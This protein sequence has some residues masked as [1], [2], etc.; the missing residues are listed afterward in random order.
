[1][2]QHDYDVENAAGVA[3]RQ[4]LNAVLAAIASL[5]SG[6]TEP[7][8]TFAYMLWA[9]TAS[10]YLKL[11]NA[12]NTAW[13]P[14]LKLGSSGFDATKGFQTFESP[15]I[16]KGGEAV[17]SANAGSAYAIDCAG[18]QVHN[19]LLNAASCA[20]TFT[21]LPPAG[22]LYSVTMRLQQDAT[23]NRA[24]TLPGS[25]K[26][27]GGAAI[28]WPTAPNK[29]FWFSMMTVDGGTNWDLFGDGKAYG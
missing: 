18:P 4:N 21:N 8:P 6:A 3:F 28:A 12:A 17:V 2:S 5:N 24:F 15:V 27:P 9:D 25:V 1:M 26:L 10:G 23:G 16:L 20:F 22:V 19:L 11:R 7:S 14:V 29:R 13:A